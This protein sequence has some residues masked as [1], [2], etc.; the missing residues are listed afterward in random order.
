[1]D[2][3]NDG[4]CDLLGTDW[5]AGN[6]YWYRNN[7]SQ[8]F[9][10][11]LV[12]NTGSSNGCWDAFPYDIDS[13]GDPDIAATNYGGYVV[14]FE[15]NGAGSWTFHSIDNAFGGSVH[16]VCVADFDGDGDGDVIATGYSGPVNGYQY[17]SWTKTGID[18]RSGS[19]PVWPKDIDRDGDV[20]FVLGTD[21]TVYWY[22]NTAPT[23]SQ[24]AGGE[25]VLALT[26]L[27]RGN[28]LRV[29]LTLPAG[30]GYELLLYS[31]AGARLATLE[32]GVSSGEELTKS[33]SVEVGAGVY[34]LVLRTGQSS[35]AVKVVKR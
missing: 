7:G 33:Y 5:S 6:V 20:D 28:A 8:V 25:V 9:T 4:D 11:L 34:Y 15:N 24:E 17:P 1:L 26:A 30:T 27:F 32:T 35:K 14:W 10:K 2:L 22:E 23:G 18:T 13:D 12:G 21:G 16:G 29:S 31:P 3:D 19:L